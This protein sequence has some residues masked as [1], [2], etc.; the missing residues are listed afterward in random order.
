MN[1]QLL[2]PAILGFFILSFL[3]CTK[4]VSTDIGGDLL[5]PIDGVNT[6]EMFLDVSS[7]NWQDTVV[8]VGISINNAL[9]YVNDPLFGKTQ[10]AINVEIKPEFFPFTFPVGKD[11]LFIDSV[12]LVLGYNGVWG[13]TL[14]N[15]AL[16]V[17]ELDHSD[18]VSTDLLR[19]DTAYPTSYN[20]PIGRELTY[21][22]TPASIDIRKLND[23]IYP[24]G[25]A[26]TNQLR[27]RLNDSY[28]TELLTNYTTD[29]I[30]G[31]YHSDSLFERFFK[32]YQIMPQATSAVGALMKI[33]LLDTNTK[34]A[35]YYKY[36]YRAPD[37][38]GKKNSAVR[39]FS[40]S[41][42]TCGSSNYI[43]RDR[44]ATQV[45]SFLPRN[46]DINDS[47][48][49]IDANPGIYTHVNINGLDTLSNKIIHRA[50]LVMEQVP[51]NPFTDALLT[52]PNLFLTPISLDNDTTPRFY[53][54]KD[55]SISGGVIVNQVSFGCIPFTKKDLGTGQTIYAYSFDISRY[56]Q[57]IISMHD[58]I[59]P[60]VLYA[61]SN[62]YVFIN[63][64]SI[65]SVFTG[66]SSGPLNSPAIGRV[67]LGGGNN[68]M[69]RM[70]LHIV[71][72]EIK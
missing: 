72:S 29:S 27:I 48:L 61:P 25:E 5:P 19:Y 44:S 68:T 54:P 1:K 40:T 36:I 37:S 69:H 63:P 39:Y 64:T 65:F 32:G 15:M 49:F 23:S 26:A 17:Y 41:N 46:A 24:F 28:G 4:I 51:D 9:G 58:E 7:K 57:G 14:N 62:D 21:N 55:V 66:S 11:S 38:L 13:D 16:K 18:A 12:V 43:T 35:I 30:N 67:R 59:Y 2:F 31:A 22:N 20:P 6:K 45:A 3:A 56:V 34:L 33:N 52:P 53:F 10:A 50:E 42:Y 71:Y 8:R 60:L 70:R 47:L